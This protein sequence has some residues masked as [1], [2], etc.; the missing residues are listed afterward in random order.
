MT[1]Q[2]QSLVTRIVQSRGLIAQPTGTIVDV[3]VDWEA[4]IEF[5]KDQYGYLVGAYDYELGISQILSED[6]FVAVMRSA[7]A[8]RIQWVRLKTHGRQDGATLR[9]DPNLRLPQP[10]FELIYSFGRIESVLGV[11]F[12][13]SADGLDT[14]LASGEEL[15]AYMRFVSRL[16]HYYVFAEHLPKS[17]QGTWAYLILGSVVPNAVELSSMTTEPKPTDAYWAAAVRC[18][19]LVVGFPYYTGWNRLPPPEVIRAE[20]FDAA[21]KGVGA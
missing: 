14:T 17:E 15:A 18:A 11:T 2:L 4:V 6:Q 3:P 5:F 8:K 21:G 7:L 19:R 9:V 13:P 20:I 10:V 16:K 12:V 1:E